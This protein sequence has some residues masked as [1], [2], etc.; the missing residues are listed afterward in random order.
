MIDEIEIMEQQLQQAFDYS[1]DVVQSIIDDEEEVEIGAVM[2][3]LLCESIEALKEFGWTRDELI[4][5][6]NDAY[7]VNLH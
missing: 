5:Q 7:G 2:F 1:M 3:N 4:T 6:I